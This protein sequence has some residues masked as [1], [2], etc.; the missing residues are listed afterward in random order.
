MSAL[1]DVKVCVC[2][3]L[4][5]CETKFQRKRDRRVND[6]APSVLFALSSMHLRRVGLAVDSVLLKVGSGLKEQ[7]DRAN[8]GPLINQGEDAVRDMPADDL[9]LLSIHEASICIY[10]S[11]KRPIYRLDKGRDAESCQI[12]DAVVGDIEWYDRMKSLAEH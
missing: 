10:L 3:Y 7:T 5:R 1:G 2:S 4:R 6:T 8:T 9:S 11:V 12:A